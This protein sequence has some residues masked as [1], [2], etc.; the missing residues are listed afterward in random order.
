MEYCGK[1]G[2]VTLACLLDAKDGWKL[3]ISGGKNVQ[4]P[5]TPSYAPQFH[6]KHEK[7]T[8]TEY[9]RR[10]V[11]EGVAH[12]VCLTYGDYREQLKLYASYAGI[13]V[14]EI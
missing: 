3:L 14:V 5:Q 6:F 8:S 9:I 7:Y 1:E 13:P 12:H 4:L 2:E 10:I 11:D